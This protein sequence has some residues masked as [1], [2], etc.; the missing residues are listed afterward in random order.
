MLTMVLGLRTKYGAVA[1]ALL[2]AYRAA[3]RRAVRAASTSTSTV[4]SSIAAGWVS[5][6][7]AVDCRIIAAS[8]VSIIVMTMPSNAYG[9]E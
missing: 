4:S 3:L 8:F 7:L 1:M 2:P 5:G 6:L 9:E